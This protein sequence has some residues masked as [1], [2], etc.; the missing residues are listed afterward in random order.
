M[1][2]TISR[3]LYLMIIFLDYLLPG[4]SFRCFHIENATNPEA[5]RAAVLLPIRSCYEWG[6]HSH[7]RYRRC[8][9]LLHCHSTLTAYAA[10]SF[11]LHFPWGHPRRTLS[12]TLPCIARTFLTLRRDHL[13]YSRCI[14]TCMSFLVKI[15]FYTLKQLPPMNSRT[16]EFCGMASVGMP[17]K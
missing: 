4:S 5:R 6:L 16:M 8:G 3:V 17:R 11:L 9:S 2:N 7:L 15:C 12:G 1:S 13:C 14:L 10:V